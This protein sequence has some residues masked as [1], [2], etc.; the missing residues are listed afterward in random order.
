[1]RSLSLPTL[2]LPAIA[3]LLCGC[4]ASDTVVE[5]APS[6]PSFPGLDGGQTGAESGLAPCTLTSQRDIADT[7]LS[8]WGF[9]AEHL[10]AT[11]AGVHDGQ[12]LWASGSS[13]SATLELLR[14]NGSARL[15]EFDA[16]PGA[17]VAEGPNNCGLRSAL[18]IPVQLVVVSDDGLLQETWDFEL[19]AQSLNRASAVRPVA[20]SG[21]SGA[22]EPNALL[23]GTENSLTLT[24]TLHVQ[25]VEVGLT[26]DGF[27]STAITPPSQLAEVRKTSVGQF[28]ADD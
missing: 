25:G 5:E 11:I 27:A 20:V 12:W 24:A 22:Y 13:S 7:E 17:T 3:A 10:L 28:L 4:G 18:Y 2:L 6:D 26:L 21:F 1:M 14:A 19:Q 23:E 16:T 9:S 15:L 8:P